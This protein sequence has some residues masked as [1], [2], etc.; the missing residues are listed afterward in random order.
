MYVLYTCMSTTKVLMEARRL[1][2]GGCELRAIF[3][4]HH[5]SYVQCIL[6]MVSLHSA[7][8]SYAG[9]PYPEPPG[10]DAG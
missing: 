8:F 6:F 4:T 3:M 10:D 5:V 9:T 1:F 2:D 7:V